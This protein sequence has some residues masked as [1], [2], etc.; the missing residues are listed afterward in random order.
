MERYVALL[1]NFLLFVLLSRLLTPA[2]IGIIQLGAIVTILADTVRDVGIGAYL[3]QKR[4]LSAADVRTAFTFA[5]LFSA[6]AAA[7]VFTY[8]GSIAGFYDEP[9]LQTFLRVIAPTFLLTPFSGIPFALMQREMAFGNIASIHVAGW[10]LNFASI[11]VLALLGFSYMSVAWAAWV[12][13]TAFVVLG[14]RVRPDLS[15]FRITFR[16]WRSVLSFSRYSAVPQFLHRTYDFLPSLVVG[17]LIS[18][19][20][21]G[22]FDRA[23]KMSELPQKIGTIGV[24]AV[25]LPGFANEVRSGH[26]L[27]QAYLTAIEHVTAVQWPGCLL[28]V[29][30][31]GPIVQILLGPRWAAVVD[32]V[33]IIAVALLANFSQALTGAVLVAAGHVRDTM[34]IALL[35]L[36]VMALLFVMASL[37]GL[38][39]AAASLIAIGLLRA[40]IS[41]AFVCRRLAISRNEIAGP[42]LRSLAVTAMAMAAPLAIVALNGFDLHFGIAVAILIGAVT[43]PGWLAGLWVTRHAFGPEILRALHHA[44]R[45]PKTARLIASFAPLLGR[46]GKAEP[47]PKANSES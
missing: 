30:L 19:E 2:E 21:L 20:A 26:S 24:Q 6:V 34:L 43:V 12:L 18:I 42:L 33:R 8:A 14:L 41:N 29:L 44:Q 4:E 36:P 37:Q 22:L 1:L 25:A 31:A 16:G 39:V 17:R 27:K 23:A 5:L 13:S 10:L 38:F 47:A 3:V 35:A 9:A 7:L 28:L 46:A 40:L 32:L 11:T 45:H 15:P